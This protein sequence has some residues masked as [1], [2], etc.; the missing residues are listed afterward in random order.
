VARILV[1]DDSS[2]VRELVRTLLERAGHSVVEAADGADG[3]RRLYGDRPDLVVLDVSMPEVDGW[4]ALKRLRELSEVPVLMFSA[5]GGESDRVRGLLGGADDFLAKPFSGPE[6][7]A[8]VTALLRRSRRDGAEAVIDT[9]DD[10]WAKVD[11]ARHEA[12]VEGTAL[13]L[14]PT[15]FRL[16][17]T[18]VRNAGVA[19]SHEQLLEQ[20][21]QE[22]YG[23]R[24][25]VKV[26]V[27]ALRRK[28][29]AA[30]LGGDAAIET[31]RGIGYR[32]VTPRR[33][34]AG[35]V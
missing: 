8:R 2:L 1:V 13:S 34:A 25:Q 3:L 31:V 20:A 29:A 9:V 24:E 5:F 7:V 33:P 11:A 35:E 17:A 19:L 15:E 32:W 6:L 16:L 26:A 23:T 28:L 12:T 21:W 10:G 18:F 27:L 4:E 22:S 30:S 14:T